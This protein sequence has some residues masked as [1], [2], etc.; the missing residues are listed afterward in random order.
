MTVVFSSSQ[1]LIIVCS[2]DI[3]ECEAETYKCAANAKCVN[4]AGSYTCRCGEG[5]KGDGKEACEGGA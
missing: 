2:T 3:D 1:F 4:T 5:F